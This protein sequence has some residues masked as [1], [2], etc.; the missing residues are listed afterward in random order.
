MVKV[1]GQNKAT[2]RLYNE[3]ITF[4]KRLWIDC[5]K[6]REKEIPLDHKDRESMLEFHDK[7]SKEF[8]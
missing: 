4:F 6:L 7:L 3:E 2:I 5:I 8:I 1:E